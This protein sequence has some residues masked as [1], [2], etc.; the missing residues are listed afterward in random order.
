MIQCDAGWFLKNKYIKCKVEW[1]ETGD[2]WELD[3]PCDV[4]HKSSVGD[5]HIKFV[6]V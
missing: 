6:N 5:Y 4:E 3:P 2:Q 1:I